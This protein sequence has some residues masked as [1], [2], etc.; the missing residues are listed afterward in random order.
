[1]TQVAWLVNYHQSPPAHELETKTQVL[2]PEDVIVN[3]G[4]HSYVDA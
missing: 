3:A 1:M 2:A 4:S